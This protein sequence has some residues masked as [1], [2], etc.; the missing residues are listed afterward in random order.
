MDF[1]QAMIDSDFSKKINDN[2]GHAVGDEV[3][4]AFVKSISSKIEKYNIKIGRWGGEEFVCVCYDF[5]TERLRT[6]AEEIR[7]FIANQPAETVMPI[8]C[9]IGIYG[10]KEEDT[11][12]DAFIHLDKALYNAKNNGRNCASL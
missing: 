2:Y 10:I 6:L 12:K 5:D 3:L 1:V 7:E 11:A 8:T 4:K 9:S